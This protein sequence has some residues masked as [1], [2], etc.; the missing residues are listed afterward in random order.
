MLNFKPSDNYEGLLRQFK[1]AIRLIK[2]MEAETAYFRKKDNAVSQ[3]KID[4]LEASLQSERE[5]NKQLT[6]EIEAME[7]LCHKK[8]H[9]CIKALGIDKVSNKFIVIHGDGSGCAIIQGMDD[10]FFTF[11]E[12]EENTPCSIDDIQDAGYTGLIPFPDN[13]EIFNINKTTD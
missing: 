6:Q 12:D 3:K 9:A 4:C 1:S 11:A 7:D 2:S 13:F 10:F 5:M 8:N